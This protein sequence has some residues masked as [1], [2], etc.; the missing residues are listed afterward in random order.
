MD[1]LKMRE[2]TRSSSQ[3]VSAEDKHQPIPPD[4]Q[5]VKAA[6]QATAKVSYTP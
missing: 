2:A 3:D 4:S 6:R 1:T 5:H